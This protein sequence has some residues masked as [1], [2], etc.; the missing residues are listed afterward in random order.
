MISISPINQNLPSCSGDNLSPWHFNDAG[1]DAAGLPPLLRPG[2]TCQYFY[3]P[4]RQVGQYLGH[5]LADE[6]NVKRCPQRRQV[7][8]IVATGWYFA[9]HGWQ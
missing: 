5:G 3:F 2:S 1:N 9:L 8:V 4:E 7:L 6:G